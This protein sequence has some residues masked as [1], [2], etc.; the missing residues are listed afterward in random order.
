MEI[1]KSSKYLIVRLMTGVSNRET[2]EKLKRP[3]HAEN[4]K[5]YLIM[6][7]LMEIHK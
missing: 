7:I 5:E 1:I 2:E 6:E 4:D 3:G